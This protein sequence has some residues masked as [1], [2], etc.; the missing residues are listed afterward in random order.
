MNLLLSYDISDSPKRLRKMANLCEDYGVRVQNSVFEMEI[1][2]AELV[3][4]KQ[5]IDKII[6]TS[7][8]SVRIYHLHKN[9][10]DHIEI[11]GIHQC[12]EL[13]QNTGIFI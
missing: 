8:D 3:K 6:D 1:N 4:L 13:S 9:F 11:I 5:E 12:I 2:A 10:K 7:V